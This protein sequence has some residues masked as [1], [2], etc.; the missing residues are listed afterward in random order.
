ML[1]VDCGRDFNVQRSI[2]SSVT[3]REPLQPQH[4]TDPDPPNMKNE[5]IASAFAPRNG[6]AET[7]PSGQLE[8]TE[9]VDQLET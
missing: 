3:R 5:S 4:N 8:I 9:L 6:N 7:V 1:C 2:S